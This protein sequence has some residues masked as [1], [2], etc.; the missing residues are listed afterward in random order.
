MYS[1]GFRSG[2][3]FA[4]LYPNRV[5]WMLSLMERSAGGSAV[6]RNVGK[7]MSILRFYAE[8]DAIIVF[9]Y[10]HSPP[11]RV[12]KKKP[13]L[14]TTGQYTYQV[15]YQYQVLGVARE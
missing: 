6:I 7:R 4:L 10:G 14:P 3:E 2:M 5:S 9:D 11:L 13:H 1:G 8:E 15:V 12:N